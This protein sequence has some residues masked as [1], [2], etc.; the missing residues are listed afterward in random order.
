MDRH[1]IPMSAPFVTTLDSHLRTRLR[2][3]LEERG[4]DLSQPA[5]TLFQAR[6]PGL[7][8][9]LYESGKL[10]IQGKRM[11]EFIEVV[12]EPEIFGDLRFT[13]PQAE[14]EP[15]PHIGGDEAGK[16]DFFGPLCVVALFADLNTLETLKRLRVC[17]SKQVADARALS[18]SRELQQLCP[19]QIVILSP[20]TYNR[21]YAR[22][23]NLNH[24]LAWAHATALAALSEETDCQTAL[25]DQ[26]AHPTLLQKALE[27]KTTTLNL[28]QRTRAE[29]DLVV[30]AA[31]IVAR[32]TFLREL[33]KL[34]QE[35]GVPLP[36]GASRAVVEA[37]Q[38]L[39]AIKGPDIFEKVAK[40]HFRTLNEIH[41]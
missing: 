22:F 23:G 40:M 35:V 12:L 21:L 15:L 13:H 36:K 14:E 32:G 5:Y 26:F 11:A 9:T 17:D 28:E 3:L 30:A 7:T 34:S 31:S 18:L 37:G 20:P 38:R 29:S 27:K 4:F 16:G 41:H 10:V 6:Q 19:T 25:V 2:Q 39:L 33:E 1:K 24:L 8:L